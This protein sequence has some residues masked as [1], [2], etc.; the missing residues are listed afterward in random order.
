MIMRIIMGRYIAE[1]DGNRYKG[2]I[3]E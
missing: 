3:E 1:F 2:N